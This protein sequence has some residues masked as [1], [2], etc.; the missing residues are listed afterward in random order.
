MLFCQRPTAVLYNA[1][2][3]ASAVAFCKAA[4]INRLPC[5]LWCSAGQHAEPEFIR[6]TGEAGR[7]KKAQQQPA[8]QELEQQ[9]QGELSGSDRRSQLKSALKQLLTTGSASG[10]QQQQ[11]NVAGLL[12]EL[13]GRRQQQVQQQHGRQQQQLLSK[14]ESALQVLAN[15][16]KSSTMQRLRQ[17]QVSIH[18]CLD[19]WLT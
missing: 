3:Q 15:K 17:S 16:Q 9:Q 11:Q 6:I 18:A 12:Q 5:L 13:L 8:Q 1:A 4:S 10:Q 2:C 19:V 14:L 7:R